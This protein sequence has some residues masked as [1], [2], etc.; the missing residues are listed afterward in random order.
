MTTTPDTI[1][2]AIMTI[3]LETRDHTETVCMALTKGLYWEAL[4]ES[5]LGAYLSRSEVVGL[6][7]RSGRDK[8]QVLGVSNARAIWMHDT[9][10]LLIKAANNP[11]DITAMNEFRLHEHGVILLRIPRLVTKNSMFHTV[12]DGWEKAE[13]YEEYTGFDHGMWACDRLSQDFEVEIG[14]KVPSDTGLDLL[15]LMT[16]WA[17]YKGMDAMSDR[18]GYTLNIET[19]EGFL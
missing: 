19:G 11:A 17:W 10:G 15:D 6:T 2:I 7:G 5:L 14:L 18:L 8:R 1:T 3:P 4:A 9:G 13:T 16:L 12:V